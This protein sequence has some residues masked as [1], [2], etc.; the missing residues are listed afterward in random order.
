MSIR[1]V[2]SDL[3]DLRG[4]RMPAE[5]SPHERT[6]I[7]FP[8]RKDFWRD[9]LRQ[10]QLAWSHVARTIAE[11]E[12]VTMLA[13]PEDLELAADLCA[14]PNVNVVGI[15][16]DDAWL[17]DCAP[18][19]VTGHDVD[20][21]PRRV[22]VDFGFNGWGEKFVPFDTDDQVPRRL[23]ELAGHDTVHVPMILEGGSITV[24]GEGTLITTEQCLL[25]MNRNPDLTRREI[26]HVLESSLGVEKVIWIPYSIDDR[27][28]DGHIDLVA[29]FIDGG[30]VLWQNCSDKSDPEYERLAISRRCL[31][32]TEDAR[33]RPLELVEL[34]VLPYCEVAGERFPVPYCNLYLCNGA[35]IVPITGHEADTDMLD[36][37]ASCYPGRDVVGVPGDIIAYGGGGPHCMTQQVPVFPS[38]P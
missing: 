10:G 38:P 1:L 33:G 15:P 32:G 11:Y 17:R 3:S 22:A 25:N 12:P 5:G 2:S 26:E 23:T 35:V 19:Y 6:L 9:R 27:D 30:R 16:L 21:T 13:R 24:D 37:I 20:A 34:P 36:I 8:C 31:V 14:H 18:I 7:A 29:M 4:L 28:T